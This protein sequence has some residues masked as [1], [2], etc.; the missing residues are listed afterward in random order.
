MTISCVHRV[1]AQ[2]TPLSTSLLI[3]NHILYQNK[4]II[5]EIYISIPHF[6]H[7]TLF[8]CGSSLCARCCFVAALFII[9][10]SICHLSESLISFINECYI[11]SV[12]LL[13]LQLLLWL[14]FIYFIK[15]CKDYIYIEIIIFPITKEDEEE[16][17]LQPQP[18]PKTMSIQNMS[19]WLIIND[20]SWG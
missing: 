4:Y 1:Y 10:N 14:E 7:S 3:H 15:L 19:I 5:S 18:T 11:L 13:L 8:V 2:P 6:P 16:E 17:K 20:F 12:C 9:M